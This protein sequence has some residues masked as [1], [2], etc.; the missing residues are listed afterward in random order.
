VTDLALFDFDH[1][2]TH[3]DSYTPFVVASSHPVRLALGKALLTPLIGAY[4]L[5]L[6]KATYL[7]RGIVA[8]GYAGRREAPLREAGRRY[9]KARLATLLR[10]EAVARLRWHQGRGDRVVVVSASL[11]LYLEEWCA[12][13]GV[14]LICSRLETWGGVL[15][16]RYLGG[17]CTGREKA[18]RVRARYDLAAYGTIYAYGDDW[19]ED[20][21][22]L[23]LAHRRFYRWREVRREGADGA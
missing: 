18:A 14:D 8:L 12:E 15:T 7:R 17:D 16:G 10:P 21:A 5:K 13:L 3:A 4:K 22:L 11:D 20:G 1:T 19:R 2:I 9:A 6:L 23:A